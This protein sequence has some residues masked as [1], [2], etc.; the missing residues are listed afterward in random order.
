MFE[1]LQHEGN[2]L[3]QRCGRK[4]NSKLKD[5]LANDRILGIVSLLLN[6]TSEWGHTSNCISNSLSHHASRLFSIVIRSCSYIMSAFSSKIAFRCFYILLGLW[7]M[8]RSP[9]HI[10][11]QRR[12][13]DCEMSINAQDWHGGFRVSRNFRMLAKFHGFRVKAQDRPANGGCPSYKWCIDW[14]TWLKMW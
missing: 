13:H 9:F 14:S 6:K 12:F 7:A 11:L 3:V 10:P 1:N 8:C 5:S 2:F 4:C